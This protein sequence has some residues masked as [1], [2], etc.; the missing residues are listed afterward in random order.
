MRQDAKQKE[1]ARERIERL[2]AL[3]SECFKEDPLLAKRYVELARKIGM[4]CQV[5]IPAPLKMRF[6][7][8]CGSYLVSGVNSRTRIKSDGKGRVVVT[9]MECGMIK[10]YPMTR[11]KLERREGFAGSTESHP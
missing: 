4:K 5:R 6:C 9:C 2:F 3:A 11:E 1:L 10:R 7:R 8:A